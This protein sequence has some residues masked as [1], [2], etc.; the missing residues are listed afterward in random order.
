MKISK[1]TI[2]VLTNYA[3]INS[4]LYIREGNLLSTVSPFGN[5]FSTVTLEDE[6][7]A[8]FGIYD[9]SDFLKIV[10]I[11]EDPDLEFDSKYVSITSNGSAVKYFGAA[12][13][14]LHTTDK[15]IVMPSEEVKFKLPVDKLNMLFKAASA[16]KATNLYVRSE[17]GK[18]KILVV[19]KKSET[20]NEFQYTVGDTELDFNFNVNI[21]SLKIIPTDYT[22]SISSKRLIKFASD[23]SDLVYY[24]AC[25]N[26][27]TFGG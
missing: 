5:I 22:V 20:N 7:P 6:F 3:T 21:E 1:E 15:K 17:D 25:E 4:N 23:A 19:D 11:F 16:L 14:V 8:D 2:N 18:I 12:K 26:D 24:I 13:E 10:N 9:I 27:S